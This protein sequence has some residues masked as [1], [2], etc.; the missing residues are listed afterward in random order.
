MV[1]W[2]HKVLPACSFSNLSVLELQELSP[3]STLTKKKSARQTSQTL[4]NTS[5]DLLIQKY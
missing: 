4:V 2:C 3:Y 5:E 1:E